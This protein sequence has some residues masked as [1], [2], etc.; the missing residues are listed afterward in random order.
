MTVS[1]R[2]IPDPVSP[3]DG[4]LSR[5]MRLAGREATSRFGDVYPSEK[6]DGSPVTEA[7]RAAERVLVAGLGEAFPDDAILGEEG[8]D[9]EGSAGTWYVD[10]IDGTGS[11]IEGLAH[12]GPTVARMA[13]G[14]VTCG[15]AFFPRIDEYY[16]VESGVGAFRDGRRL[17]PLRDAPLASSAVVY[18][19]SHFHRF[20]TVDW[21]GKARNLGSTVAHLALVAAGAASAAVIPGGWFIWD[22][23]CGLAL[24][25]EVGGI[26]RTSDGTALDL[27]EIQRTSGSPPFIAG[28]P[29]AV[30]W[31]LEHIHLRTPG[32]LPHG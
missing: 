25:Q 29:T 9:I 20:A 22:T 31:L 7:D 24:I 21:A 15:A 1:T 18:L 10:P 6:Q 30:Q 4:V 14:R 17:R 16:F 2:F 28:T 5:L 23:A 13:D 26:V 27:G 12:W 8:T 11:Y 19:P 3:I 32:T